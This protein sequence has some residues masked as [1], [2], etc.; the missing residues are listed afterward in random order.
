[1]N[2]PDKC[3]LCEAHI[4]AG[5][6]TVCNAVKWWPLSVRKKL[7]RLSGDSEGITLD[8]LAGKAR[9]KGSKYLSRTRRKEERGEES[10]GRPFL[11]S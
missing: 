2:K 4:A 11:L 7:S 5:E 8:A 6:Q 1:M 3:L 9:L 10:R